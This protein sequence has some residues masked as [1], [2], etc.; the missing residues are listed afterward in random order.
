M[1]SMIIYNMAIRCI[2]CGSTDVIKYGK[3]RTGKQLYYCK[4]CNKYWV[5][6]GIFHRYPKEVKDM[7]VRIILE[8]KSVK[9]VSKE[10]NIPVATIYKWLKEVKINENN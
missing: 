5:K 7:I 2:Y 10:F 6:G 3:T 9:E 8:G 4:S 1:Q